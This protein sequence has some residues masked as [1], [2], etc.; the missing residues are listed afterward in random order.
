MEKERVHF[1]KKK[2]FISSYLHTH[3]KSNNNTYQGQKA[4][5]GHL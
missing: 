1:A 2:L 5:G 4:T 3:L